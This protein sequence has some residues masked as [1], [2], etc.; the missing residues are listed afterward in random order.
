MKFSQGLH[1]LNVITGLA[2][3][4]TAIAG[5]AAGADG[6]VWG[7]TREHLFLCA[8]LLVLFA[9]WMSVNTIHHVMLEEKGK[10]L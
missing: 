4:I 10:I 9:I 5:L 7:L 1:V 8:G 3:V 6:L 2:G